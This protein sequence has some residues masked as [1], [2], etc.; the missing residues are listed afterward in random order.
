MENCR[1]WWKQNY[2][3]VAVG[4]LVTLVLGLSIVGALLIW[5]SRHTESSSYEPVNV[6]VPEQELQSLQPLQTST[7]LDG[8]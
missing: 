3:A 8:L 1:T 6:T 2:W 5:R 7:G 4:A